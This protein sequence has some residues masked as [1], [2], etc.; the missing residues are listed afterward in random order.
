VGPHPGRP[1]LS[2]FFHVT[3]RSLSGTWCMPRCL[4]EI[5][6]CVWLGIAFPP[7]QY[8]PNCCFLSSIPP[9]LS[10]KCCALQSP[11]RTCFAAGLDPFPKS[12][13]LIYIFLIPL[14]SYGFFRFLDLIFHPL[15]SH[16]GFLCEEVSMW[17]EVPHI[18]ILLDRGFFLSQNRNPLKTTSPPAFTPIQPLFNRKY[19]FRIFGS[20]SVFPAGL[21]FHDARPTSTRTWRRSVCVH[22]TIA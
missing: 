21:Q 12:P 16:R 2:L 5:L 17:K 10:D 18:F 15:G 1:S 9:H 20:I 6:T 4:T 14:C 22:P 8:F 13:R 3:P 19:I 7:A 11:F